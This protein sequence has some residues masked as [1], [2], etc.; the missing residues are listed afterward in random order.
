MYS[1]VQACRQWKNYILRNETI[2]HTD[3]RPLQFIQTQG[4]LQNHRHH[5]WSTYMKQFHLNIKYKKGSTNNVAYYLSRPLIVVINIVLNSCGHET[6]DWLLLYKSDQKFGHTYKTLLEGN[7]V[8]NF[9]LQDALLCLLGH[10]CVPSSEHAKMI[11][12][13]HYSRA[14][15]HFGVEKTVASL[16]KYFYWLN[17]RQD[18]ANYIKSCAIPKLTITKQD[19]YTSFPTP[20]RPWGSISMDYMSGIP[21]T[22]HGNDCVFMV[23]DIFSKMA[24]IAACKNN[25]TAEATVQLFFERVWVHFW[26]PQSIITDWESRFLSTFWSSL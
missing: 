23:V 10:L 13:A 6:S 17:L 24:M 19:L 11:W 14:T 18:V 7:R 16:Q 2:I 12:E 22:K 21:S 3:H 15:G 4:K 8:P 5:K 9:Y 26:I 20:I 25:I 1:I